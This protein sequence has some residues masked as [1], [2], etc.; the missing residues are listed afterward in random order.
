M[1]TG[2]L[3]RDCC[4]RGGYFRAAAIAFS[5]IYDPITNT[6]STG[7]DLGTA[8]L[9]HTASVLG[10]GSLLVVGGTTTT[11][12][13]PQLGTVP[14][15]SVESWAGPGAPWTPAASLATARYNHTATRLRDGSV[16]V[17]G[18]FGTVDGTPLRSALIYR[19]PDSAR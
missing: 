2:G 4:A 19:P 13:V 12:Q 10:D 8:R 14:L 18:G 15:A 16:L 6:W 1:L 3:S 11:G 17:V 9:G 5:Q 7:P